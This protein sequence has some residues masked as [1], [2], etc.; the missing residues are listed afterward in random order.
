MATETVTKKDLLFIV[1]DQFL[2][3]YKRIIRLTIWAAESPKTF[4]VLSGDQFA[5][6]YGD[7][8]INEVVSKLQER[9]VQVGCSGDLTKREQ[10]AY[11]KIVDAC[12][13]HLEL[14]Q[15]VSTDGYSTV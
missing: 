5:Q 8:P 15:E 10:K 14:A 12:K 4:D 6:V 13:A 2:M 9:Y 1:P 11:D 7:M 3:R